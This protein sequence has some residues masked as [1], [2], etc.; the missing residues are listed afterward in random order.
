MV[1]VRV[2]HHPADAGSVVI[3]RCLPQQLGRCLELFPAPLGVAIRSL[4]EVPELVEGVVQTGLPSLGREGDGQHQHLVRVMLPGAGDRRDVL[5]HKA[6][7]EC[8]VE[9]LD[10]LELILG[11]DVPGGLLGQ[12]VRD[13]GL[14]Q[15]DLGELPFDDVLERLTN[16]V[17]VERAVTDTL[18]D[19]VVLSGNADQ[20]FDGGHRDLASAV[21][22]SDTICSGDLNG[23]LRTA[24]YTQAIEEYLCRKRR[25]QREC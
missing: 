14:R 5:R 6:P 22:F 13:G 23:S 15:L 18:D 8:S 1:G 7:V 12:D 16:V 11:R 17:R 19:L 3:P 10:L 20:L 25:S 24:Y 2:E 9:G 4:D 21:D